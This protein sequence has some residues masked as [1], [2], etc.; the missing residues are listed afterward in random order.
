MEIIYVTRVIGPA[1]G[2]T[3][4]RSTRPVAGRLEVRRA[5]ARSPFVARERGRADRH[6]DENPD[7]SA[8]QR[9]RAE[10]LTETTRGPALP[11]R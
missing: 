8:P 10:R 3:S 5:A 4:A 1:P 2:A 6:S 11:T 7:S 9:Q